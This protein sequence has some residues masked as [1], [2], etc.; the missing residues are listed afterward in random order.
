MDIPK[1]PPK[2]PIANITT[3][4]QEQNHTRFGRKYKKAQRLFVDSEWF[5][6]AAKGAKGRNLDSEELLDKLNTVNFA[7]HIRAFYQLCRGERAEKSQKLKY[8]PGEG[9]LQD[10]INRKQLVE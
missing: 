2:R 7:E 4:N 1:R 3:Y 6:S 10:T 9:S 5:P 8:G